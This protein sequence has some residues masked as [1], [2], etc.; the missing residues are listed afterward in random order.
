MNDL[1]EEKVAYKT[2]SGIIANASHMETM[3]IQSK[4]ASLSEVIKWSALFVTLFLSASA[5][6]CLAKH[7]H[8][9]DDEISRLV[10]DCEEG[11]SIGTGEC[12]EDS[13]PAAVFPSIV[14]RP[15]H[16]GTVVGKVKTDEQI[17]CSEHGLGIESCIDNFHRLPSINPSRSLA[18]IASLPL[19]SASRLQKN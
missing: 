19:D 3:R 7:F 18:Q 12:A 5:N 15:R 14:G 16:Q 13:S 2:E 6:T 11:D 1:P 10:G 4:K 17:M 8:S 9:G